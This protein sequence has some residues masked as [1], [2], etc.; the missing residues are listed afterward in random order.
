VTVKVHGLPASTLIK[1]GLKARKRHAGG[2]RKASAKGLATLTIKFSKR[3][4][5]ALHDRH[6]KAVQFK[7]TAI[8]P[9]DTPSSVTL[10]SRLRR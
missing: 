1:V 4:R 10:K 7:A 5:K 3:F 9:G 6:L 2:K 8:P